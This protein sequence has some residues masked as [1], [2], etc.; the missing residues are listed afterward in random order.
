[1]LCLFL[2]VIPDCH[3]YDYI[4][5]STIND[6]LFCERSLYFHGIYYTFEDKH[7]KARPQVNGTLRHQASD[8]GRYSSRSRYLQGMEIFS[9]KLGLV[10]KIDIYDRET[11]TLIERKAKIK[12]VHIGYRYQMY[13]QYEALTEM[14]YPVEHM[15]LHSLEDNRKYPVRYG[16]PDM[17]FFHKTIAAMRSFNLTASKPIEHTGKCRQCIYRELCRR[18]PEDQGS[19]IKSTMTH[20]D[21][22]SH[23]QPV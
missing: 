8:T 13:A 10:G 23:R 21:N 5:I 22:S 4:Q 15:V 9:H 17:Y 16:G 3:M 14:G 7:Y 1:M 20:T 6:F 11:R 19:R 18:L 2:F 12:R